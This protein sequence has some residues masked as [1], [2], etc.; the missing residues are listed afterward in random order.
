M[1]YLGKMTRPEIEKY[2]EE[3]D[4]ALFP[5][6]STEQHGK[7]LPLDNDAFSAFEI[8]KRVSEK[9][10]VV[11]LPVMPFGYSKHH[12]NFA[13]SISLESQTLVN[14][15]KEVCLCLVRHGFN[16]IVIM[17]GHGGNTNWI[18]QAQ[19]EIFYETGIRVY[20]L[21]IFNSLRGFG[22]EALKILEQ[23]GG[24]HACE[25]ETSFSVSLGQR[26]DKQA[27]TDWSEPRSWTD[28]TRKYK[29]KVSTTR[30]FDEVTEIGSLGEPS[31]YSIEKGEKM[32][33]TVVNDISEFIEDLK[34]LDL[35]GGDA[36]FFME[37][38]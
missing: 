17:N 24:G 5:V 37:E 30:M 10:G 29:D 32:V 9:T 3:N 7:H 11:Y 35:E 22:A 38:R 4:I 26:V 25:M 20:S 36:Y 23:E 33:K 1:L 28:F 21:M 13:G 31:K 12:L 27:I 8:A 6:G 15:Y 16:K 14:A 19:A 2:L 34:K 18:G